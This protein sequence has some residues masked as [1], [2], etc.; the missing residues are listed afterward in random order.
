[1]YV[2]SMGYAMP[3]QQD[4]GSPETGDQVAVSYWH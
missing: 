4:F 2:L 3:T 1:M